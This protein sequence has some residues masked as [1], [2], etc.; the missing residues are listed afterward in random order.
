MA[1]RPEMWAEMRKG[2]GE[3][4][5]R[6]KDYKKANKNFEASL[7]HQPGKLDSVYHLTN[8]QSR[9]ANLDD[10]LKLLGEK[11][12]LGKDL[13]LSSSTEFYFSLHRKL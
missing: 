8:T 13:R 12:N 6:Q 3:H 5:L 1:L 4:C 2:I 7:Q 10:A 9:Q 11:S